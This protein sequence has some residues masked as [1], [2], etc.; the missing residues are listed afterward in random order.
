[1]ASVVTFSVERCCQ[2]VQALATGAS[3]NASLPSFSCSVVNLI[4]GCCLVMCLWNRCSLSCPRG[5]MTKESLTM[6]L[7]MMSDSASLEFAI[8]K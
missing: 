1:M 6:R 5:Q 8:I 4:L 3:K 2:S 7:E